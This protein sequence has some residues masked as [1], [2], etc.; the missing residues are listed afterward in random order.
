MKPVEFTKTMLKN[1][2]KVKSI[3]SFHYF[4]FSKDFVF[5]GEKHNFW[6]FVYVDRGQIV[7]TAD[8]QKFLLRQGDIIFH[9]PNEFH[10][11]SANHNIAP[12][13]IVISFTCHSPEMA[14]FRGKMFS[15]NAKEQGLLG[16]ILQS[17]MAAF[18]PPYD[19]PYRHALTR[20][21]DAPAAAEQLLRIHLEL[22]LI[23]LLEHGEL[24]STKQ[25]RSG[26]AREH[27]EVDLALRL[28]AY[29]EKHVYQSLTIEHICKTFNI[30]RSFV[31]RLYKEKTGKSLM[32]SFRRVK[33]EHAKKLIR[34]ER[35]NMSEIAEIL[36]YSSVHSFSRQFKQ[37]EGMSPTEYARTVKAKYNIFTEHEH[38][39]SH[40]SK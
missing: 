31:L 14:Y 33:I 37:M 12:N 39:T 7:A 29:F 11:I 6:E 16:Q 15:L 34:E 13:V 38:A 4:E 30:S 20:R 22:L 25:R 27:N 28:S 5:Y 19:D 40:L 17:G 21:P 2:L 36:Q 23:R 24:P 10:N 35:N 18:R 8:D 26:M 3:Q 9:K 1:V 32:H